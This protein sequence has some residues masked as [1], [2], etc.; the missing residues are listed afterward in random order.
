M[1]NLGHF[2]EKSVAL[3][4]E[5]FEDNI[6]FSESTEDFVDFARCQRP[7]GSY[8]GT[9][10]QCRKGTPTG[11]KEKTATRTRPFAAIA[12][13]LDNFFMSDSI[14]ALGL[15]RVAVF[16]LAPVGVPLRHCPPVP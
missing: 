12:P 4:K 14:A 6:E 7:D 5:H 8:Y 3:F 16:S 13:E 10:G 2:N 11:A 15:V 9:S 1:K